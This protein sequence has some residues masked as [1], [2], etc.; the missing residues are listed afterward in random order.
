MSF[1]FLLPILTEDRTLSAVSVLLASSCGLA[2]VT[3]AM[4]VELQLFQPGYTPKCD[5]EIPFIGTS[6]CSRVFTSSFSHILSHWRLVDRH[7]FMDWSLPELAVPYF[8]LMLYYPLLRRRFLT[9]Y[10]FL[11]SVATAFNLYLASVMHFQLKE[12]CIVC[13][14]NYVLNG[15]IFISIWKDWRARKVDKTKE[16]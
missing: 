2:V 12:F 3:Y 14:A 15:I 4:L 1:R 8:G 6:S 7:S 9:H 13:G 5:V 16:N 11:A 10:F